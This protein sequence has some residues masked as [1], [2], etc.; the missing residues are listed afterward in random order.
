MDM[1]HKSVDMGT[2]EVVELE[3]ALSR[4]GDLAWH[5]FK[6][7]DARPDAMTTAELIQALLL[8]PETEDRVDLSGNLLGLSEES[9]LPRIFNEVKEKPHVAEIDLSYNLLS[10]MDPKK[11]ASDCMEMP[12]T[13]R[14]VNINNNRL[15]LLSFDDFQLVMNAL[16]KNGRT[17]RIQH[18]ALDKYFSET[19]NDYLRSLDAK[20]ENHEMPL[21]PDEEVSP[22]LGI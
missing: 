20:I 16:C 19:L 13:I 5:G 12:D 3:P 11:L 7:G 6:K 21:D 15:G 4:P 14:I 9:L 8:L 10:S 22:S 1:A 2:Y 17:V 18:N